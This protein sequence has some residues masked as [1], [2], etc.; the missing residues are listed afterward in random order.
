MKT[1]LHRAAVACLMSLMFVGLAAGQEPS[2]A[3]PSKAKPTQGGKR[4]GAMSPQ[5]EIIRAAYEK[6]T[7]L[8]RAARFI[9]DPTGEKLWDESRVLKF[10]LSNFRTGPIQEIWGALIR[11]V[12]TDYSGDIIRLTR[13]GTRHNNGPERVAYKAQWGTG[14]YASINDPQWTVGDLLSYEP[15]KYH[16]V[17]E[18]AT[19]DVAV[20]F[21]GKTRSY[22]ALALFHNPYMSA[23]PL[24][25]EFWDAVVGAGG[26]ITEA[27]NERSPL[28]EPVKSY[29]GGRGASP[30]PPDASARPRSPDKYTGV[31]AAGVSESY[32]PTSTLSDVVFSM[33]EDRTEH[34]SGAHGERVGFQGS[35]SEMS[36]NGQLCR[37][38]VAST[39]D[40]DNGTVSNWLYNHV[41]QTK[42]D[43]ETATGP[44]G[45]S[46]TCSAAR[47]IAVRNC[48]DPRCSFTISL[49]LNNG[50]ASMSGGDVWN[51]VLTHRHTCNLPGE[52]ASLCTTS[53]FDG[54][55]PLG[56]YPN[57]YGMCCSGGGGLG[58]QCP[59]EPASYQC[60]HV[61][62]ETNCPYT[63]YGFG[64]CYSPVLV[65]TAGDGFALTDAAGGVSFDLDGNPGGARERVSWTAAGADDA[66]L[67][68]DRNGNG[69][70]DSGRELF[71]N[72]TV[73]PA[74]ATGN[75]FLALA[76]YDLT[77]NGGNADG[78]ID[79]GDAVFP[80]LRLWRD[81]NHNG[82]SEAAELHPLPALGVARL[83]LSYKESRKTDAH[84]NEFR[85]RAKVDDAQ[86][87]KVNRWA[88]DVFLLVAR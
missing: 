87:E 60:G 49:S 69:L 71:G 70:I 53:G 65:D 43:D 40:Y 5:E 16:D 11:R 18:Y 48:L 77:R 52:V 12:S 34:S 63:I 33:T 7:T 20:S 36:N 38:S 54:G 67:A 15:D 62:P 19:Y 78:R 56:A 79:G 44:R 24:K 2:K 57:E 28:A 58:E 39:S 76:Q 14:R 61:L 8:N 9:E 46:I 17:R 23:E 32:S 31:T 86:G 66:W 80:S 68:L 88:W 26:V 41:Y 85:Y 83:H 1:R 73:Q 27:W 25:P 35:C 4:T 81:A 50:S 84:G 82:V 45:T 64:S 72:L 21:E 13:S 74:S 30:G 42:A 29:Q 22:S 55:C 51:G 10:E 47:G 6:L 59:S 37:V 3:A 75:G